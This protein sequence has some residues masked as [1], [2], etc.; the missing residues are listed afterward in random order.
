MWAL[1]IRRVC[2]LVPSPRTRRAAKP[3]PGSCRD[4]H[5]ADGGEC[6]DA[7]VCPA[8]PAVVDDLDLDRPFASGVL[9][10]RR[11]RRHDGQDEQGGEHRNP[12]VRHARTVRVCA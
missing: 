3:D 5:D 10:C 12:D 8:N 9:C 1:L 7:R 11:A 6:A 2:V 4:E